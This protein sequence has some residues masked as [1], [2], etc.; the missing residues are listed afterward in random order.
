MWLLAE[1]RWLADQLSL[2]FAHMHSSRGAVR[3]L[4]RRDDALAELSTA[5]VWLF[6]C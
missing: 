1:S 5:L 4:P 6:V 2:G 3:Q